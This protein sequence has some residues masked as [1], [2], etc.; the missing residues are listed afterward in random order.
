MKAPVVV[1]ALDG[2]WNYGPPE[3]AEALA[4]EEHGAYA[5]AADASQAATR[6]QEPA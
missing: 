4:S 1:Q 3:L 6:Y 2:R 5:T